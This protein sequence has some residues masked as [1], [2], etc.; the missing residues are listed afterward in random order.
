MLYCHP[1]LL[2]LTIRLIRENKDDFQVVDIGTTIH[3]QHYNDYDRKLMKSKDIHIIPILEVLA[4]ALCFSSSGTWAKFADLP[5]TGMTFFRTA[6][7]SFILLLYLFLLVKK[8]PKAPTGKMIVGSV[9]NAMRMLFFFIAYQYTSISNA[10]IMLYTWPIFAS[11][12]NILLG[13]E[14]PSSK[15]LLLVL[16]FAGIIIVY[17]GSELSFANHDF[18]GMSSMLL[19][20]LLYSFTVI[21]WKGETDNYSRAEIILYQNAA[22]ALLFAPFLFINPLPQTSQ[23]IPAL[24]NGVIV[25]LLGF[26]FFF[27]GL[28]QL[29][30]SLASHLTYFEVP[31]AILLGVIVF[32]EQLSVNILAGGSMIIASILLLTTP[33]KKQR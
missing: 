25:G 14:K 12:L 2:L 9:L 21:I 4:A 6:I 28:R 11:I 16:A 3:R 5:S 26:I 29:K 31:C 1:V 33:G 30:T 22:A 24:M 17:A 8:A 7:P 13:K 15:N 19:S 23:L 10:I 27:S 32:K 18:I 20:S